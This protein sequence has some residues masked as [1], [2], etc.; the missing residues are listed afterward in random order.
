MS[1]AGRRIPVPEAAGPIQN[2]L[3]AIAEICSVTPTI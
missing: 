2:T 3:A 1:G